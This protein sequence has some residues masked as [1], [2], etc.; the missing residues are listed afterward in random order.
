MREVSDRRSFFTTL[1]SVAGLAAWR[2]GEASAQAAPPSAGPFDM[3]WLE[4]VKGQHKQLYDLGSFDLGADARPMRFCKNFLDTFRDVY[5]L[6]HPGINTAAGISGPAIALNMT[7]RVWEK[8]KLGER[9]KIIDPMTKQPSEEHLLRRQR[10]QREGD[11]GA[12]HDFLAVQRRARQ[13]RAAAGRSVQDAVCGSARG[14]DCRTQSRRAADALARDVA[15]A[16]PGARIHVHAAVNAR[17]AEGARR[18][19][20]TPRAL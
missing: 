20:V 10:H 9:S 7:D 11:A 2:P 17:R 5:K 1:A 6:E 19:G 16:R 15:R 4:Q 8:Y 18:P 12:R 13:R 14:F 3:A